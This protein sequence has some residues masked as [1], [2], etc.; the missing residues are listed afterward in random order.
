M[1]YNRFLELLLRKKSGA[2]SA[3]EQEELNGFLGNN[4]NYQELSGMVEQLYETPLKEIREVDRT[5]LRKRWD[6]LKQRT[7]QLP[8]GAGNQAPAG[9][10]RRMR[11]YMAAASVAA[12]LL[13]GAFYFQRRGLTTTRDTVVAT[14]MGSKTSMKLP[15]GSQVWL[16]AG[17]ELSYDKDFGKVNR[18][19]HLSGEAY[20]DVTHDAEH[21]FIVHTNSFNIRV[22]G[23][24][25]NVKAYTSDKESEA[26]LVRGSIELSM[27]NEDTRKILLK[28]NEKLVFKKADDSREKTVRGESA[29]PEI[30]VTGLQTPFKDSVTVETQWLHDCLAFRDH[31]L[32]DIAS[33]I[34][35]WY[36]VT[37]EINDA[38]LKEKEFSGLFKDESVEQVLHALKLAG[39]FDYTISK[40]KITIVP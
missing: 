5:Y 7:A 26:T 19:V 21:P 27:N 28:P 10:T 31:K 2:L 38:D 4:P 36:G 22:L 15:D 34:S 3:E 1:S 14:K 9:K 33:M 25:F 23:T 30:R 17:S 32:K 8:A 16:N 20:F 11:Y 39:G 40:N 24:A 6:S 37:V 13:V 12:L 18:E 29:M 35:R